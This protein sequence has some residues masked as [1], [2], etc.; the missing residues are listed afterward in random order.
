M[1]REYCR[2]PSNFRSETDVDSFLRSEGVCG[3]C[4]VDTRR[5]TQLIRDK[6]VMNAAVTDAEPDEALLERVRAHR[7]CGVVDEV[8]VKE[9]RLLLPEGQPRFSVAMLDFG[10]KRSI[11]DCL[12][13]QAAPSR[14][15]RPRPPRRPSLPRD[16]T[17]HALERPRRPGG[18]WILHRADTPAHG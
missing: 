5:I 10:Y 15:T 2:E 17:G 6:G 9:P 3:I 12:L 16:T 14:S 11:G 8:T 18:E 1:V 13:E 7:V 4:G